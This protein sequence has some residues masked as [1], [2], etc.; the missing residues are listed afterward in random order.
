M[1]AGSQ[2]DPEQE[3]S[4]EADGYESDGIGWFSSGEE[5]EYEESDDEDGGDSDDSS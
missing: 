2:G 5:I 3:G 1:S 4:S